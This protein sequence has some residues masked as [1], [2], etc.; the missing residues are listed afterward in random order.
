MT[1]ALLQAPPAPLSAFPSG[2]RRAE[3]V[4]RV[5][6]RRAAETPD[7]VAVDDGGYLATYAE[8]WHAAARTR[9]DLVEAGVEPG[10]VVAIAAGRGTELVAAMLGVWLA[11]AACL[12]VG[13]DHL[14]LSVPDPDEIRAAVV[15]PGFPAPDGVPAVPIVEVVAAP[16]EPPWVA[17]PDGAAVAVLTWVFGTSGRPVTIRLTHDDLATLLDRCAADPRLAAGPVVLEF[18]LPLVL[19]ARLELAP[20]RPSE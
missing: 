13:P 1:A 10:D 18:F 14:D 11:G 8:L 5:L 9:R 20:G 17:I 12:P 16:T 15:A 7:L 3:P 6:A 4:L 19:G 2:A